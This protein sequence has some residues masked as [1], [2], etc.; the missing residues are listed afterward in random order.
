MAVLI[1]N[2]KRFLFVSLGI[3]VLLMIPAAAFTANSLDINVDKNGDAIA[4]FSFSLEGIVENAIPQSML[5]EQLLKGLSTSSEPPELIAMDRSSATIRMKKYADTSDVPTGTE[6]RTASVNFKKAEIALQ[7]SALSSVVTADF[8]PDSI[9]VTFPDKYERTFSSSD[10]LPS[11]THVV[12][13]PKK[14]AAAA[15]SATPSTNGA[16]KILSSPDGVQVSLDGQVIGTAPDTFADIPAG[17]HTLQFS[18][19]N[20]QPVSK[21]LTVT[22]GQTVQVSV[23]L[24]YQGPT[25]TQQAPGYGLLLAAGALGI[26]LLLRMRR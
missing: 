16:I 23:F 3:A 2:L 15:A 19:D 6:Y 4:V 1:M 7:Q 21:T 24:S 22:A 18:K 12:I 17:T 26:C 5:E 25:P 10:V 13:D 9:K 8:S 14:A 20:Y 11:I